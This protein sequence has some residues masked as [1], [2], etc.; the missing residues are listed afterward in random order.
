[1]VS[2]PR[3][4][5][6]SET[7]RRS[8]WSEV[9]ATTAVSWWL[10]FTVGE[11]RVCVD[12][13]GVESVVLVAAG[14]PSP[15]AEEDGVGRAEWAAMMVSMKQQGLTPVVPLWRALYGLGRSGFDFVTKLFN[16]GLKLE[17]GHFTVAAE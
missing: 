9:A 13:T 5:G 2:S 4:V 3:R 11:R 12:A 7:Y 10:P 8:A 14:P 16:F 15:D 17:I 1:M 6:G